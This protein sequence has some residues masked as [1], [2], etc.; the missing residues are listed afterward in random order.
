MYLPQISSS[1]VLL[2]ECLPVASECSWS[3]PSNLFS[4]DKCGLPTPR[5]QHG[6]MILRDSLLTHISDLNQRANEDIFCVSQLVLKKE[7]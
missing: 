2:T 7:R 6:E 1:L 3:A 5:P 4:P